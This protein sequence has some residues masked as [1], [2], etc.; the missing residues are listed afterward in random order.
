MCETTEQYHIHVF[1]IIAT[2]HVCKLLLQ[3][4]L[5]HTD[6]IKLRSWDRSQLYHSTL[7]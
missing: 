5:S 2:I 4:I 6:A 3:R 7:V 1:V